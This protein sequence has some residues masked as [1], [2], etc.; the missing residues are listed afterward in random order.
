[1]RTN[2]V[3]FDVYMFG[4]RRNGFRGEKRNGGLIVTKKRKGFGNRQV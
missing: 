2:K 1:V 4:M 3:V